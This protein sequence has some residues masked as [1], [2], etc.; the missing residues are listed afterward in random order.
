MN[1][2][3]IEYFRCGECG[4]VQTEK[5]YWLEESY[6]SAII[7]TDVGLVARNEKFAGITSLMLR[8][9]YPEATCC[10]DYGGGYGMMTRMLRDRGH[11]F[12]HF[13][14]YCENLFAKGFETV[15]GEQRFD[16]L[17]AF[18]VWEHMASPIAEIDR[19]NMLADHWLISTHLLPADCPEPGK[20][21]YYALEGGQHVSIWTHQAMLEIARRYNRQYVP[22]KHGLHLLSAKPVQPR[23]AKWI[24]KERFAVVLDAFRRRETLT[25]TD[26]EAAARRVAA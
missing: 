25:V 20:W 26:Y 14:P 22:L 7:D 12:R 16:L 21:W 24:T 19:M 18:E 13:D 23:F 5:P 1:K 4:F 2:Y 8:Y 17:T 15:P 3:D 10:V 11:D 9:L 6:Q